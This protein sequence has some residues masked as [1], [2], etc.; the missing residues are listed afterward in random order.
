MDPSLDHPLNPEP[1]RRILEAARFAAEKHSGQ[2]RKGLTQEPY[3]NHVLEVAEMIAASLDTL[4]VD[5]IMAA[6][7]HDTVEDTAT[8]AEDLHRLFGDDVTS[9]VLEVT[10]DRSLP[11][12]RRKELQVETAPKKTTRAQ[13]IKLA[14]K[15]SNLRSILTSP[16]ADWSG[17]RKREYFEWA[18]RVVDGLRAPDPRLKKQF[19]AIYAE[20][21]QSER[22]SSINT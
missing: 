15:I 12:Q 20:F 16:P 19:D 17:D 18:K 6:L 22:E 9:L 10:D 11:K 5:L 7:L 8:T 2:R 21:A 13:F 14:D 3:I 4:D 1:V